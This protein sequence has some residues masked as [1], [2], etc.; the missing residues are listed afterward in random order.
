MLRMFENLLFRKDDATYDRQVA[1]ALDNAYKR[2]VEK[3]GRLDTFNLMSDRYVIFSD[4]HKGARNGA[5]DFC[6]CE[7]IYNAALGYYRAENYTL[8]ELGDVEDLWEERPKRVLADYAKSL[9]LSASFGP[10]KYLRIYGNHDDLWSHE[11]QVR[12]RLVPL[13]GQD[14][15][16][17]ESARLRVTDGGRDLGIIW[18]IHGHQG[19][20]DSDKYRWLSRPAVRYIWR[21][22]QRVFKLSLNTPA[23]DWQLSQQH[24]IA[25][26]RWAAKQP[27]LLMIAGHTHHPV[28]RS[29]S[30]EQQLEE[31]LRKAQSKE[32][33]ELDLTIP[34]GRIAELSAELEW[35]RAQKGNARGAETPVEEIKRPAYFNT[36]CCCYKDGDITGIELADGEIRLVRWAATCRPPRPQVLAR[37]PLAEVFQELRQPPVSEKPGERARLGSFRPEEPAIVDQEAE[38]LV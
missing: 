17:H 21:P 1:E 10:K 13:Y 6:R 27:R 11:G 38:I 26:Y 23:Q 7:R 20:W 15:K 8:V 18:L 14:I 33:P 22:I 4:Q 30:H 36:G 37:A 29:K 28:F 24:N 3:P 16:V 25:L 5:D 31:K 2:V 12:R 19:T 32:N 34:P 9:Q 35:V